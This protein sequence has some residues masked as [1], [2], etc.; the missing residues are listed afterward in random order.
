[1]RSRTE[2]PRSAPP[3][4]RGPDPVDPRDQPPKRGRSVIAQ[5][6][7][8]PV[9]VLFAFLIAVIIKTFLIQAFFIPSGSMLPTLKV[10]DRVLVEKV[11]YRLGEV[12]RSQVIVFARRAVIPNPPDLPWYEDA[13]NFLRELLGLPTGS[14]NDYIKRVVALEGDVVRYAGKPRQLSVNGE[15]VAEPYIKGGRDKASTSVTSQSCPIRMKRSADGCLV[16]EGNL[17]VMGDNRSNSQDSRFIGPIKSSDVVG[18]AFVVLWP[19][20]HFGGL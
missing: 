20:S 6:L 3:P 15:V 16:P 12:E 5:I 18:R 4:G 9:L 2:P 1:M 14:E 19:P 13:R 10:G 17:F 7:E 8:L 11:G